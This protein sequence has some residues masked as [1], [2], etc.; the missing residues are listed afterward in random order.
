MVSRTTD[1]FWK[2]FNRLPPRIQDKANGIY[3]VW[4]ND[5]WNPIFQFKQIHKTLPITQFVLA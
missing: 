2:C 4:K 1:K 5:P 3:P